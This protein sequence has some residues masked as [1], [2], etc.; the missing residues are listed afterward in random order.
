[1]SIADCRVR[2]HKERVKCARGYYKPPHTP[3]R[4]SIIDREAIVEFYL[5]E[6]LAKLYRSRLSD[7]YNAKKEFDT[8]I[9]NTYAG[10]I[11]FLDS[12]ISIAHCCII[13]GDYKCVWSNINEHALIVDSKSDK[14]LSDFYKITEEM[15]ERFCNIL[16]EMS[17][18]TAALETRDELNKAREELPI[19]IQKIIAEAKHKIN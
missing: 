17:K 19:A 15:Y 16:I 1:M 5:L 7:L 9:Q 2:T 18:E 3:F 13:S 6:D 12:S 10:I 4:L 8:K 14:H 11:Y